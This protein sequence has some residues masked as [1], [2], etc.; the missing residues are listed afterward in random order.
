MA[1]CRP[2]P[3]APT[4]PRKASAASV[5][6]RCGWRRPRPRSAR[7]RSCVTGCSTR[8]VRPSPIRAGCSPAATSTATT[9]SAITSGARSCRPRQPRRQAGGGRHLPAAAATAGGRPRRL[10][11]R[12]R[13]RH[14]RPARAP[15]Q[16][17]IPRARPLLRA[18]ALPQQAHGRTA[19]ARHPRLSAAEPLRRDDRLRQPRRHR[20]QAAR[21][22]AVV[23]ASLCARAA[24]NGAPARC[25]SAMSR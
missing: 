24:R 15:R 4:G 11:H 22:A 5:P 23:P 13:I 8:R 16:P 2:G 21:A 10:L 19:L 1:A 20:A 18:G 3:R 7:P 25:P 14:R 12:R 9:R 17:A 6:W